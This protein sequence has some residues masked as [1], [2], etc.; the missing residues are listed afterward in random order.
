MLQQDVVFF[1]VEKLQ[2]WTY[3]LKNK[4]LHDATE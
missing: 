3:A 2:F 1:V 4:L